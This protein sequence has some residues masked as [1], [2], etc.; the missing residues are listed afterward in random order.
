ML[1]GQYDAVVVGGGVSGAYAAW[2][3]MTGDVVPTSPIPPDPSKR[4]IALVELSDRIGGRLESL[5]PP[6]IENLRAEFGGMAFTELDTLV[7]SVVAT[8]GLTPTPFG[9]GGPSNLF[10]LRGQ[11]FTAAQANDPTFTPPY[12]ISAADRG[13]DPRT[14]ISQTI[15]KVF[16]GSDTWTWEKWKQ[17]TSKGYHGRDFNDLGFWNFLEQNMTNEEFEYARDSTGHTFEVA[18]WNCAQALPWFMVDGQASEYSTLEGGYAQLPITLASTFGRNGGTTFMSTQVVAVEP[19]GQGAPFAVTAADGSSCTASAVVLAM[20]RRA[21]ES[22]T[23][24]IL[25]TPAVQELIASVTGQPVLKIFCC[26]DEA[27]W[28]SLGIT[29]GSS[30]TDLPIGQ[31]WYW[32][33]DSASNSNSLLL[34]SYCDTLATTYWEGLS[35]GPRFQTTGPASPDPHWAAQAPSADMVAE[36]QRQLELFHGMTVPD[37]YSAAWMDWSGDPY[38]GAYNSWNVGV[39]PDDVAAAILQPDP[40]Q[41]LYVCGEA[42][43]FDQGWV[44]GALDTAEQVVERLGVEA[45]GWATR[46]S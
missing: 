44:E 10:Y 14:L 30:G 23:C 21:L 8:L 1:Q 33:P 15:Q 16:P 20:P 19:G 37:P 13:V 25:A 18:N 35:S 4:R 36:V 24:S 40:A 42:Y 6:G 41:S 12:D 3:L 29:G 45:P 5:L 32:G 39:R 17:A 34:A 11:R 26:Y 28:S 7:N 22:L 31:T 27:W 2:R 43:S 9:H 46:S 38:G